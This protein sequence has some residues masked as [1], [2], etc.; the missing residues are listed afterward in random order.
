MGRLIEV[1]THRKVEEGISRPDIPD[2]ISAKADEFATPDLING[3]YVGSSCNII[4]DEDDL[5]KVAS[6]EPTER[7]QL[8]VEMIRKTRK[9]AYFVPDGVAP[10][11]STQTMPIFGGERVR[12]YCEPGN[13]MPYVKVGEKFIPHEAYFI[14]EW[15][16]RRVTRGPVI[17]R[18]LPKADGAEI[19]SCSQPLTARLLRRGAPRNDEHRHNVASSLKGGTVYYRPSPAQNVTLIT[20]EEIDAADAEGDLLRITGTISDH[21]EVAFDS[22][23]NLAAATAEKKRAVKDIL[24]QLVARGLSAEKADTIRRRHTLPVD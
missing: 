24:L 13:D 19:S 12:V 16:S 15:P 11:L 5:D 22:I 3:G 7:E 23:P 8:V 21:A 1:W 2:N 10:A 9:D 14:A 20:P 18:S 17:A 6:V 4:I